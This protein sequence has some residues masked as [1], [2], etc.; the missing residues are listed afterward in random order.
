MVFV[1]LPE[2]GS[3]TDVGSELRTVEAYLWSPL[4]LFFG[5]TNKKIFGILTIR[6]VNQEKELQWRL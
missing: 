6:L 1:L 3:L 4:Q 5:P 2:P